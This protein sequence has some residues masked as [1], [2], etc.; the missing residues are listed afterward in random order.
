MPEDMKPSWKPT[1]VAVIDNGIMNIAPFDTSPGTEIV[2]GSRN[3]QVPVNH[4][5]NIQE[6]GE[7]KVMDNSAEVQQEMSEDAS[8]ALLL[9]VI[10][11]QSFLA[12]ENRVG[13]WSFASDPHGTQ[14]ASLICA[15]DPHCEILVAKVTE[16]RFGI[17]SERLAI[18][19]CSSNIQM[20]CN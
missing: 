1:K 8:Q 14:M 10:Q 17:D 19:S 11:G 12:D 9:R 16:G 4:A 6:H 15:I 18:V 3:H 5:G 2:S 13:S 7:C 20:V